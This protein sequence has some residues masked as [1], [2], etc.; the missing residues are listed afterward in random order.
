MKS[1]KHTLFSTDGDDQELEELRSTGSPNSASMQTRQL[2]K[3]PPHKSDT[4]TRQLKKASGETPDT[5]TRQLKGNASPAKAHTFDDLKEMWAPLLEDNDRSENIKQTSTIRRKQQLSSQ[6][7]PTTAQLPELRVAEDSKETDIS[8]LALQHKL[9]EGGMGQIYVADQVSLRR[10]VVVKMALPGENA[11]ETSARLLQESWLTGLLEHPNI[12]P[13]YQL[14]KDRAGQPMLVMK[15]I[16]GVPWIDILEGKASPPNDDGATEASTNWHIRTLL[17]VC[18]AI[19]F[20]HN[21][22]IIHRDLKPENVMVGGFGEVY[23]LDWGIAV[24]LREEDRGRM[25][26]AQETDGIAGTPAYMAPEMARG[27]N[28]LLGP[29][30]DIYLLGA[31]LHEIL[32][33]VPPHARPTMMESL[34]SIYRSEP[35]EYDDS[36]PQLLVDICHKAMHPEPSERY[37]NVQEFRA[38][39]QNYLRHQESL[40]LSTRAKQT[41]HTF[42]A[43]LTSGTESE[44]EEQELYNQFG[45]CQFGLQHALEIWDKN[46]EAQDALQELL[47][48]MFRYEMEH[49]NLKSAARWLSELPSPRPELQEELQLLQSKLQKKQEHVKTL[50]RL[51]YETDLRVG[52]T[53]RRLVVAALGL[54]WGVLPLLMHFGQTMKWY[55][56]DHTD[57]LIMNSMFGGILILATLFGHRSLLRNEANRRIM[58]LLGLLVIVFFIQR[59]AVLTLEIPFPKTV[60]LEFVIFFL[61]IGVLAIFYDR[62]L[63]HAAG[64]YVLSFCSAIFWPDYVFVFMSIAHFFGMTTLAWLWSSDQFQTNK[65]VLA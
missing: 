4:S 52:A 18:N 3:E 56:P 43:R 30:S 63:F 31:I 42:R 16:E 59:V 41:L 26:L 23:V 13:V 45:R 12:V 6:D 58:K 57:F 15:R 44:E 21:K 64:L 1:P 50:E 32:T 36:V 51:A 62:M 28:D 35:Q 40:N 38:A 54:I 48:L 49:E 53:P 9:A 5:S 27:H 47:E 65:S 10:E 20:A 60:I 34:F 24:S 25:P 17:Q 19:H 29:T 8:E 22:G 2:K 7:R 55:K 11:E 46:L 37:Q 39:L 33:G 61:F 14:G